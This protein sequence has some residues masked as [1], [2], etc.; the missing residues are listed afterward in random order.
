VVIGRNVARDARQI[1]KSYRS[2]SRDVPANLDV[3]T[4]T[5][6]AKALI[7]SLLEFAKMFE[8]LLPLSLPLSSACAVDPAPLHEPDCRLPAGT[9]ALE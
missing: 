5:G 6:T 8:L 1:A 4:G 9:E 2:L 7:A 3:G